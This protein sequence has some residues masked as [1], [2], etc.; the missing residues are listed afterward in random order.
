MIY[1]PSWRAVS[2][3]KLP[4]V[5]YI[6]KI[7][8]TLSTGG[9]NVIESGSVNCRILMIEATHVELSSTSRQCLIYVNYWYFIFFYSS[10]R[11]SV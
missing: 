11:Q 10:I 9:Y 4:R 3:V 8:V 6:L 7:I 2:D 5:M 1:K